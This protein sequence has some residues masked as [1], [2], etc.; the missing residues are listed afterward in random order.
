MVSRFVISKVIGGT[1]PSTDPYRAQVD[2]FC[3][4]NATGQWSTRHYIPTDAVTGVPVKLACLSKVIIISGTIPLPAAD[5][6]IIVIPNIDISG[7]AGLDTTVGSQF[8]QAQLNNFKTRV[9]GLF[10][11]LDTSPLVLTTTVRQIMNY[12]GKHLDP[13]IHT[14][15]LL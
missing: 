13:N 7:D 9:S 10:P 11:Q 12:V 4:A 1:D 8:S 6:N 3:F 15:Q 2:D 14:G 5:S